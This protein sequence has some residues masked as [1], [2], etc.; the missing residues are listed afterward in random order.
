MSPVFFHLGR[1]ESLEEMQGKSSM[2]WGVPIK[3]HPSHQ[4]DTNISLEGAG[5][6]IV[7]PTNQEDPV[8]RSE[9]GWDLGHVGRF[10]N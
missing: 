8:T 4:A 10:C 5:P 1:G 2:V 9:P 3:G 7:G 6:T